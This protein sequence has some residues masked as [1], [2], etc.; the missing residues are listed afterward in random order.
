MKSRSKTRRRRDFVSFISVIILVTPHYLLAADIGGDTIQG[1]LSVTGGIDLGPI[2]ETSIH[3][4]GV[5]I[6]STFL[7]IATTPGAFLWRD[8]VI[9]EPASSK[10]KMKLDSVNTLTLFKPT[11]PEGVAGV[12]F[13]PNSG[14]IKLAGAA[15]G[16]SANGSNIFTYSQGSFN[17]GWN[18]ANISNNQPAGMNPTLTGALTVAGGV[19]IGMD[20]YING[21]KLGKGQGTNSNNTAVG[22]NTLWYNYSGTSNSAFGYE[23]LFN[24]Y[25]GSFNT[26]IG[27]NALRNN[28]YGSSNTAIGAGALSWNYYSSSNTAVGS[29]ALAGGSYGGFNTGIGDNAGY[30]NGG[31]SNVFLGYDA[32]RYQENGFSLSSSNSVYIGANARGQSDDN[33]SIVIGANAIGQGA[34]TTVIGNS[35]TSKIVIHG[36]SVSI[37][38]GKA[39]S[40]HAVA[41]NG[42]VASNFGATAIGGYAT[43]YS[44]TAIS[45][46]TASGT[47]STAISSGVASGGSST[48][49]AGGVASGNS[50]F[51]VGNNSKAS[52]AS[53]VAFGRYNT[54]WGESYTWTETDPLL[55]IG[56]GSGS[57][58]LSNAIT[59]LKNGNTT[60]TNK[61]WKAANSSTSLNATS[62][63]ANPGTTNDTDSDGNALVVEG[64]TILNGKVIISVPQGDISMGI[65]Q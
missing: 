7:D 17:F 26:A 50:S 48:A 42:G 10:Q 36:S 8:S 5:P 1:D 16:I 55:L 13:E 44:A 33:N 15:P 54:T 60:L 40:S 22:L 51:A 63:L 12:T 2:K 64:H 4:S 59:T 6:N 56:N 52:S 39:T 25:Y 28:Y 45:G 47:A 3:W 37:A 62:A 58:T 21:V 46:G 38:G 31:S 27:I 19:A 57:T 32:G 14:V 29:D 35:K 23:A 53:S 43:S 65:Y 30:S 20:S 41:I 11:G 9:E 18:R 34:N 49:I 61:A 24:N